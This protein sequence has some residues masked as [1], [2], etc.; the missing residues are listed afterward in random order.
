MKEYPEKPYQTWR[1]DPDGHWIDA[2]H[3][4]GVHLMKYARDQA[5]STI[6][7]NASDVFGERVE[8]TLI[9][10]FFAPKQKSVS[11]VRK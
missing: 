7:A 10:R 3:T 1:S 9:Y 2:G 5:L 11:S 6:P 4:F 8:P